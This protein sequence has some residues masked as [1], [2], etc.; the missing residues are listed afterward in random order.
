M[1]KHCVFPRSEHWNWRVADTHKSR[2]TIALLQRIYQRRDGCQMDIAVKKLASLAFL[3]YYPI[4][5]TT[6]EKL[7]VAPY[8]L[9]MLRQGIYQTQRIHSRHFYKN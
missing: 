1:E 2:L 4:R 9:R 8:P 7:Y 5:P 3:Q 6:V